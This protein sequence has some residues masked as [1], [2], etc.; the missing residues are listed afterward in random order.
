MRDRERRKGEME[1]N[2]GKEIKNKG[3]GSYLKF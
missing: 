3:L 2:K 1:R